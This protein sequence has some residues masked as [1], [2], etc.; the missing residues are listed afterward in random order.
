MKTGISL[1]VLLLACLMTSAANAVEYQAFAP[2]L[3]VEPIVETRYEPVTR[4]VCT[5]PDNSA[6]EFNEVAMTIGEDI[7]SQARRWQQQ[8]RCRN[9]TERRAREHTS[10]YRVTYR[11]GGVTGTTRR[12]DQPG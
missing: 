3:N 9:I 2:V 10:A 8:T 4:R 12:A 11:Y 5:E 6:R 1:Q 7:R